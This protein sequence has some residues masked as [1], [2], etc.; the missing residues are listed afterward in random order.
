MRAYSINYH[1][2]GSRKVYSALVDAKDINSAKSKIGKKHGY[3]SGRMIVI[4]N[5]VVVGYF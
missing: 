1:V 5:C 2:K 3:K 4:D